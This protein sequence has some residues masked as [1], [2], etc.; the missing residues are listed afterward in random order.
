VLL[1]FTHWVFVFS[2]LN[3]VDVNLICVFNKIRAGLL[4][5][6]ICSFKLSCL[7]MM[8]DDV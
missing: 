3:L 8:I 2:K 1:H 7:Q 6:D 5:P 4:I